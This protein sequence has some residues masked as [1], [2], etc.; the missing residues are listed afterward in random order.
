M[1]EKTPVNTASRGLSVHSKM[2]HLSGCVSTCN[3]VS[4]C[5]IHYAKS[6]MNAD[7][8]LGE[9]QTPASLQPTTEVTESEASI[10]S[11]TGMICVWM[12]VMMF[13]DTSWEICDSDSVG[14]RVIGSR[15]LSGYAMHYI[16][17]V[18]VFNFSHNAIF[19]TQC[20]ICMNADVLLGEAQTPSSL[21][22]TKEVTESIS[23]I[24]N[25]TGTVCGSYSICMRVIWSLNLSE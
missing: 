20:R 23:S 25:L 3:A 15:N 8:L 12:N 4:F 19:I 24:H 5:N 17:V 10:P 16:A 11:L 18:W 7:A 1:C 13:N 22:P 21:Q 6:N 14:V 2:P 9:A